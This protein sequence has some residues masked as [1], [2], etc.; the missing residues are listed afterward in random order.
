MQ[1]SAA[2]P[3]WVAR[4]PNRL[5][6]CW[7]GVLCTYL[8]F[9]WVNLYSH[10]VIANNKLFPGRSDMA[11]WTLLEQRL[12][13]GN[14]VVLVLG[15]SLL[16][17]VFPLLWSAFQL[18][19]FLKLGDDENCFRALSLR[20]T[21]IWQRRFLSILRAR[22]LFSVGFLRYFCHMSREGMHRFEGAVVPGCV[23]FRSGRDGCVFSPFPVIL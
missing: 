3:C 21:R 8:M 15:F 17:T 2:S 9:L 6:T 16:L 23:S 11:R 5:M 19:C 22:W 4:L 1:C 10:Y 18:I 14:I 20:Y 7:G 12:F 13:K